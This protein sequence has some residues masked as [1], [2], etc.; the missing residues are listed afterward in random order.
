MENEVFLLLKFSY[1]NLPN[2][3]MKC[4]FLYC[5]LYPEDYCIP[6][7]RLME[8]WF[9]EGPLNEFDRISEA[10]MQVNDII[11]S[12]LICLLE[13]CGVIDGEDSVKMHDVIHDMALW[14]TREF[15]ATESNFFVKAGDQ[16]FKEPDVKAWESGKRISLMKNKIAVLKQ[17]PKCPNLR[18]LF[19]SQNELQMISNGFFQFIP[20]LIVL[21]L[22]RNTGLLALP[23]GISQ[24][25]SLEW[26]DLSWTGIEELP[27]DLKALTKLKMLDLSYMRNL[28]K[29]PQHLISSFSKL[30]I[31]K[32]WL[33]GIQLYPNED[34]VLNR[35]N[36]K[37]IEELKGLQCLNI[38]TITIHNMFSLERFLSFNLF[39]LFNVLCLE[40]LERLETLR[41]DFGGSMEEIK[42]EILHTWI[43]SITIAGGNKLRDVTR[44]IL[45]PNLSILSIFECAKME[46]ILSEGKLGEVVEH[47]LG[48]LTFPCLKHIFISYCGELR[49][50]PLNSDSAKWNL[51]T[52]E[53]R[54]YWWARLEW[55]NKATR[56]AFL[57]SFKSCNHLF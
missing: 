39:Q 11:S 49:K 32:M 27:L 22:S 23:E 56:D 48:C 13:N 19:L 45:A 10:Q 26:F 43:S 38:L 15:E 41:F 42:M 16:L 54:E 30:Q 51:L 37:L 46:E 25:V 20:R 3:T 40:K 55:E 4:C 34:N 47:I 8:Y 31:F 53:G 57:P 6:R 33:P 36:E 52:I 35:G 17:T 44:L 14:I 21:D 5:C 29:L 7:K 1:D 24:L 28:R 9:C 2:A 12:L 18:T 50:P